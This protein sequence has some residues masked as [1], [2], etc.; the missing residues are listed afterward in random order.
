M[1]QHQEE[2]SMTRKN[3]ER[4][5]PAGNELTGQALA[6]KPSETTTIELTDRELDAICAGGYKGR[7]N[8]VRINIFRFRY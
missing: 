4:D 7:I 1:Q 2:L 6:R 8:I 5:L 3:Q